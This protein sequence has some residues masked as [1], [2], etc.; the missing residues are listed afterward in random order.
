MKPTGCFIIRKAESSPALI[1]SCLIER[2]LCKRLFVPAR[3]E[4]GIKGN[5]TDPYAWLGR[6]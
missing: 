4:K 3:G 6:V 2:I 5:S 1:V